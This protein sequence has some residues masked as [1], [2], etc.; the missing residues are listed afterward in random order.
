MP[1]VAAAIAVAAAARWAL[2][3]RL[4]VAERVR[5]LG[6]DRASRWAPVEALH[7]PARAAAHPRAVVALALGVPPAAALVLGPAAFFLGL[8]AVA[9][10][11]WWAHRTAGRRRRSEVDA[12]LPLALEGVARHLRSGAS[13]RQA[14]EAVRPEAPLGDPWAV[15]VEAAPARGVGRACSAWAAAADAR[16]SERLAA[17]AL[18]L[19]ADTGGAPARS[20]DGVAATLRARGALADELRALT[21]SARASAALIAAAPLAFGVLAATTDHRTTAYLRTTT[22]QLLLLAGLVLDLLGWW[23]MRVLCRGDD[24]W[25]R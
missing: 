2:A 4:A 7:L 12:Q 14:L 10:S 1:A 18:G 15:L 6:P 21:A 24:G 5:D 16:P 20:V 11:W 17:A 9:G 8:A 13:L 3:P 23:W 22:G 25:R 19:A